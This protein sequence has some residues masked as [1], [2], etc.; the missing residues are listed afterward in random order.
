MKNIIRLFL[1]FI[2]ST[3]LFTSFSS[4]NYNYDYSYIDDR[5]QW[6]SQVL[7]K[8]P[9][10]TQI[11]YTSDI[12]KILGDYLSKGNISYEK[13]KLIKRL[14]LINLSNKSFLTEKKN[15]S[16]LNYSKVPKEFIDK[17]F[18]I[19][20]TNDDFEFLSDDEKEINRI[21]FNWFYE[22]WKYN[23]LYDK[24]INDTILVSTPNDVFLAE[25]YD[26]EKKYSYNSLENIF[27]N[28]YDFDDVVTSEWG[29]YFMYKFNMFFD[30]KD[31]YWVY[32]SDLEK[33]WIS[34]SESLLIYSEWKYR[35]IKEYEKIKLFST[36]LYN[37]LEQDE[38]FK[39]AL[40]QE[41]LLWTSSEDFEKMES[42]YKESRKIVWS[43]TT[44][45]EKI[46]KIYTWIVENIKYDFDFYK[47]EDYKVY[48][49]IHTYN[50]NLWVCDG[51]TKLMLYMSK[52]VWIKDI[53]IKKW[54]VYNID[55]FPEYGHAWIKIWNNYY[56]PTFDWSNP[57][58]S[59]NNY[60]YYS[61]PEEIIYTDRFEAD[62]NKD[63]PEEYLSMTTEERKQKVENNMYNVAKNN[64]TYKK[65]ELLN[66]YYWLL[67]IWLKEWEKL[68][69][70]KLKDIVSY[71]EVK[72]YSYVDNYWETKKITSIKYYVVTPENIDILYQQ[73]WED[74]FDMTLFYRQM[75][76]W[77]EYRLVYELK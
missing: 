55:I 56:D 15:L 13:E 37:N 60:L 23:Y 62:I 66:P 59:N 4:A 51:Y 31:D 19:I 5:Y 8:Y 34:G 45:E 20:Y 65:Y 18:K 32:L 58:I 63:I 12:D 11:K 24:L 73:L 17:W 76:E 74:I 3:L 47:N 39:L 68:D 27:E 71:Y 9:L 35:F 33:N 25:D 14:Q 6:F 40:V 72:N 53:S 57:N 50:R 2:L 36:Y 38:E 7:S 29:N 48:S 44:Q 43:S 42:I 52:F 77:Y 70:N 54:F 10:P 46:Q 28:I 75:Q 30:N 22:V 64:P 26:I 21:N 16:E 41:M 61:L 69:I 49:G 1:F 67:S